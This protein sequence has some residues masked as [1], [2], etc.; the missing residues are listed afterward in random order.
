MSLSGATIL[1]TRS[2]EQAA[3]MAR[4]IEERGGVPVLFPALAVGPPPSWHACDEA[5]ARIASFDAVVFPSVN[6]V[7]GFFGRCRERGIADDS[8]CRLPL[9]AIGPATREA[10]EG[11]GLA[12]R[13]VPREFSAAGLVDLLRGAPLRR[14]LI[15][16]GTRG[17][18]ELVEALAAAGMDVT[19]VVVYDSAPSAGDP[20]VRDRLVSGGIDVLTFASPSAVEGVAS[21]IRPATL[22][23]IRGTTA[24]A[25]I[26]PTTLDAVRRAGS[27]ADIVP[28]ESTVPAMLDAIEHYLERLTHE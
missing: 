23:G 15:P 8:L 26:G 5:L 7:E 4:M 17:R 12:V 28:S 16:R 11:I 1:V 10:L 22:A 20:A 2:P 13:G 18:A 24:I 14:V 27:D 19:P 3:S 21:A 9:Y 6:A 25:V